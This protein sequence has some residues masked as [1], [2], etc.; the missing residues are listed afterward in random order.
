MTNIIPSPQAQIVAS[1]EVPQ[2]LQSIRPQWQAKNLINR[3][4]LLVNVDPSSACQR[5]FN[6][7][8]HDLREK[9]IIAGIDIANEA[10]KAHKMSHI[11]KN[12][13]VENYSA[14]KLIDLSFRIGLLSRPE[15]RRL[16][17]CYE[18][19]RDLE[20][21]DD[22]YEAGIEDCVYIFKTCIDVVLSRDPIHLL[23][24]SDVK[25]LVEVP[26]P[27]VP[28]PSLLEDF[29]RAPQARQVEI[30][31]FLC[32]IAVN[33]EQSDLVR[34]N[35]Y[36]F[37]SQL[38]QLTTNQSKLEVA[39]HLQDKIKRLGSNR[40]TIRVAYT[41]G[42]L[43]YINKKLLRDYYKAIHTNM[44][45]T[46]YDWSQ[47]Q[48]HSELL[49]SFKEIGGLSHCPEVERQD[50]M[51]WLALCY[52]G[53]VGGGTRYGHVRHVFYSD[54]A[55][56]LIEEIVTDAPVAIQ[57]EFLETLE[58][59]DVKAKVFTKHLQRRLDKLIDVLIEEE[60]PEE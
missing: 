42:V 31:K 17:R 3:V 24:V 50:I 13:D 19:R 45:S 28:D 33:P 14:S 60:L 32:S 1:S 39:Q 37:L 6:A 54:A 30:I 41:A 15:W 8:I 29:A 51:L 2:L 44:D 27:A 49:H 40:A 20:H 48:Y 25:E 57:K 26:Q 35:A 53:K 59:Q 38:E 12:E 23:R 55:E 21:E 52:I 4:K 36:A 11:E 16:T 18:I 34:Q 7:T 10:A 5:L 47:Y 22:E 9:V 46:G 58:S 43:P 56:P